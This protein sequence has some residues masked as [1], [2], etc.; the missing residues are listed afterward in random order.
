MYVVLTWVL[1]A[2]ATLG[3]G[4]TIAAFVFVPTIAAPALAK[5]TE[6]LLGCTKCLVVAAFLAVALGS[7]WYGRHSEYDKGHIAAIAEIAA[8]DEAALARAVE[9]R[10]VWEKCKARS[11]TWNQSTGECS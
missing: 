2:V 10:G 3:V 4:G 5:V 8:E 9:T 11:G 1:G 7:Y 6:T